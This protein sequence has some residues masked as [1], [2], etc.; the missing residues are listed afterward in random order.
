MKTKSNHINKLL[1]FYLEDLGDGDITTE[2]IIENDIL[3]TAKII[4]KENGILA[5]IEE[6]STLCVQRNLE[7]KWNFSDGDEIKSSDILCNISGKIKSILSVERVILNLLGHMCG[8]ATM[9]H[10]AIQLAKLEN[11]DIIIAGTRKTL[12]GLR[13]FEK[14]AIVIAGGNSHRYNLGDMIL[15]KEKHLKISKNINSTIQKIKS[16]LPDHSIEIEIHNQSDLITAVNA[17]ADTVLLDNMNP[18]QIQS[19]IELL[20]S[21]DLRKNIILEA[22]GNITLDNIRSYAK[23][24]VDI[25]SMGVLTHSSKIL[26]LSLIVE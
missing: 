3:K 2:S 26:D 4:S 20:T 24:G 11:N 23:T 18:E 15:I 16:A 14:K 12:P 8:V 25:I 7:I 1:N 6:I 13:Y 17:G 9:T 5:G 21:N 19:C 22:S 10:K